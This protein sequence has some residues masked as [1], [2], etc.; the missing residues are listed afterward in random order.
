MILPAK[1]MEADGCGDNTANDVCKMACHPKTR[2][3]C[4]GSDCLGR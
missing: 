4:D 1:S 3:L 2:H